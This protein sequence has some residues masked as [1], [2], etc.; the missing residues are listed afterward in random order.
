[1]KDIHS[2][3]KPWPMWKRHWQKRQQ[4]NGRRLQYIAFFS[5]IL[6]LAIPYGII[7]QIV[8]WMDISSLDPVTPLD[9]AIPFIAWSLIPYLS[10][11]FYYPAGALMSPKDDVSRIQMLM[12]HQVLF[13]SSWAISIIFI[14]IPT[15]V[16]I[17]NHIPEDVRAGDGFW[18]FFYGDIMHNTD[19]PW[20]AWP[21]LHIV[22][23]LLIVLMLSH[24]LKP[25]QRDKTI[26]ALWIGWLMLAISVLTTKQHFVFDLV[27]GIIVALLCWQWLLKPAIKWSESEAATEFTFE[28]QGLHPR[29]DET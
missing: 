24:W 18:G 15:K 27:T 12:L 11:Y 23:S 9:D 7:N 22:Q 20:N 6:F 2:I 28:E 8:N 1:M 25:Q 5:T 13:L 26:L 29:K 4:Q 19:Q 3:L 14:L 10:L 21:S 16:H 17:R